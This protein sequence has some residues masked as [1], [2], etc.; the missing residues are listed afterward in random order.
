MR[1]STTTVEVA[2]VE[3]LAPQKSWAGQ[4]VPRKEDKRLTQG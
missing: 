2:P 4:S 1:S 3:I